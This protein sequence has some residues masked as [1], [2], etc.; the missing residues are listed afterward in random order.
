MRITDYNVLQGFSKSLKFHPYDLQILLKS[1]EFYLIVIRQQY[2]NKLIDTKA[3]DDLYFD[4][5]CLY[6]VLIYSLAD[7]PNA[8]RPIDIPLYKRINTRQKISTTLLRFKIS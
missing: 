5:Y 1:L 2:N 6:H 3:Y 7:V 4:V 8:Y